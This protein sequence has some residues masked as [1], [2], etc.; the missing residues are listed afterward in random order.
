MIDGL[1]TSQGQQT[2]PLVDLGGRF[3][4]NT[5]LFD[6]LVDGWNG[7][8]WRHREGGASSA[9]WVLGHLVVMRLQLLRTLG[10]KT[11][12]RSWEEL[13][14]EGPSP[15]PERFEGLHPAGI[16]PAHDEL[17]SRFR[18]A[19]RPLVRALC[20]ISTPEAVASHGIASEAGAA[21]TL[22]SCAGFF[23][24]DEAFHL[25]QLGLMRQ[26]LGKPRVP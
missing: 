22:G 19:D 21:V 24:F 18:S 5:T 12:E 9:H 8:D 6:M 25:G 16:Y 23:Y 26:E 11:P 14:T 17:V 15:C 2:R 3:R 10:V 20:E 1:R 13:F 7:R 4:F